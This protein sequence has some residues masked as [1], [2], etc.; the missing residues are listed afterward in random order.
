MII[1]STT[2]IYAKNILP[3]IHGSRSGKRRTMTVPEREEP[4]LQLNK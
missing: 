3:I 1:E 2:I 4:E